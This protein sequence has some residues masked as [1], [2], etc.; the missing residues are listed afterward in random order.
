MDYEAGNP[1]SDKEVFSFFCGIKSLYH[2]PYIAHFNVASVKYNYVE[3]YAQHRKAQLFC[4]DVKS[5]QILHA[6]ESNEQK[7]DGGAVKHFSHRI[8]SKNTDK[9]MYEGNCYKFTQNANLKQELLQISGTTIAQTCPFY[10]KWATGYFATEKNCHQ[11]VNRTA[12][13]KLG[14]ILTKIR[15]E[16]RHVPA[17]Q[18]NAG[19]QIN[20]IGMSMEPGVDLRMLQQACLEIGHYLRYIKNKIRPSDAPN[21]EKY[22]FTVIEIYYT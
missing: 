18:I 9:L 8:W 7:R 16:I 19:T 14:E 11:R 12:R 6:M 2:E 21:E 4:N 17:T 13:N 20:N 15:E 22:I 3:Q 5:I 1:S 10:E